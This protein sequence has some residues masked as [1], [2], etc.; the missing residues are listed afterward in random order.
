MTRRDYLSKL[1]HE[2]HYDDERLR[3]VEELLNANPEMSESDF[4]EA[5]VNSKLAWQLWRTLMEGLE[6]SPDSM[7]KHLTI[8]QLIVCYRLFQSMLAM[9]DTALRS[10]S[11]EH[12]TG[13]NR[14]LA[15]IPTGSPSGWLCINNV[16]R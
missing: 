11:A 7:G 8:H 2:L 3:I 9:F 10:S 6:L 1:N 4:D 5:W 14:T 16:R 15:S 12:A 13:N